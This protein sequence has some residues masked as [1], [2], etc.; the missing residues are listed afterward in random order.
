M[1]P[2]GTTS[3]WKKYLKNVSLLQAASA[4]AAAAAASV[5]TSPQPPSTQETFLFLHV[6]QLKA[7][8]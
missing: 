1:Y 3:L 4:A 7:Y 2:L 5:K 6:S 8:I